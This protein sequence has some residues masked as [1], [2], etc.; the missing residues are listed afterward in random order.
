[1]ANK[2]QLAVD[3]ESKNWQDIEL[4]LTNLNNFIP[5]LSLG[6]PQVESA[7]FHLTSCFS[8]PLPGIYS[9]ENKLCIVCVTYFALSISYFWRMEKLDSEIVITEVQM[10]KEDYNK[11]CY[12]EFFFCT[13]T[14][15]EM[16]LYKYRFPLCDLSL[17]PFVVPDF[18]YLQ[19]SSSVWR[20]C[21]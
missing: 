14:S 11:T 19:I 17:I 7:E 18:G 16:F 6:R 13:N 21:F 20:K 3:S 2:F 1:M 5:P 4:Y 15:C 9:L 12:W 10:Y 8:R